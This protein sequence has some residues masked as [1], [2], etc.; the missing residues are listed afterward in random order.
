[1]L[2]RLQVYTDSC[3]E[4]FLTGKERTGRYVNIEVNCLGAILLGTH[5]TS[6]PREGANVDPARWD[7]RIERATCAQAD[8][9]SGW[10]ALDKATLG[11][12]PRAPGPYPWTCALRL[13]FDLLT[14]LLDPIESPAPG[15]EWAVGL[16]KCAD[17]APGGGAWGA[18]ADIGSELNFHQPQRFG[19]LVFA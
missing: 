3:V 17:D 11:E 18:W 8:G 5:E 4:I 19:R 10:V 14:E 9:R 2:L 13:P 1:M 6:K 7:S 15:I 16:F 12:E